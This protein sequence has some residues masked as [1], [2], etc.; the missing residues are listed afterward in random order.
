VKI[1]ARAQEL[2]D[3]DRGSRRSPRAGGD[4]EA[5]KEAV[6]QAGR[7]L[8]RRRAKLHRSRSPHFDFSQDG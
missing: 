7:E 6:E 1:E 2:L 3:T 5:Y 8:R 4:H